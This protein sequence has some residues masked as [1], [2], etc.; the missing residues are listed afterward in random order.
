MRLRRSIIRFLVVVAVVAA[1]PAPALARSAPENAFPNSAR[2]PS[3]HRSQSSGAPLGSLRVPAIGIDETVR[4]GVAPSVINL[5]VAHWAGTAMPG[6]NGNVVLAGHRTTYTRPFYDLDRLRP[7]DLV[8]MKV[9]E[10]LEFMYKV[11]EVTIVDPDDLWITY[12]RDRPM[13]TMFAC[14]PKGSDRYRI[15][16]TADLVAGRWIS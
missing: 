12:D 8:F 10:G 5:G 11:S 16:V 3:F 6:Q 9:G 1:I 7:G 2:Q 13:L 15:V 14:H 4:S